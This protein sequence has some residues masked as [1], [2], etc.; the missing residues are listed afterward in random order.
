M[1]GSSAHSC[2]D[3]ACS[4]SVCSCKDRSS[5]CRHECSDVSSELFPDC[6]HFQL[7]GLPEK[8]GQDFLYPVKDE[9]SFML[10]LQQPAVTS[11]S[12]PRPTFSSGTHQ[13][14]GNVWLPSR[15][16]VVS[17]HILLSCRSSGSSSSSCSGSF[18]VV[19]LC[20]PRLQSSSEVCGHFWRSWKCSAAGSDS[21]KFSR[22]Q[23]GVWFGVSLLI[24][25]L[26]V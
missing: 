8:R 12:K 7:V 5:C 3:P 13:V 26:K 4:L 17:S 19:Q 11:D 24:S 21:K 9:G 25:E 20:T 16:D 22:K 2:W 18:S 6:K 14:W 23:S 1:E 10:Q 15:E